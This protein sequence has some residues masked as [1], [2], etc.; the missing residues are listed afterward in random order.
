MTDSELI[1]IKTFAEIR[2]P[3]A[4]SRRFSQ[5]PQRKQGD[6]ARDMVKDYLSRHNEDMT[7]NSIGRAANHLNRLINEQRRKI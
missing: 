7:K 3:Q 2:D 5:L 6:K 4:T 1:A